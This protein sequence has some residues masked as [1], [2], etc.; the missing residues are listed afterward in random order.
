MGSTSNFILTEV[1]FTAINPDTGETLF[2]GRESVG[3]GNRTGLQGEL[4]TCTAAPETLVDPETGEP[5]TF[6]V[7]AEGFLTSRGR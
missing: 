4:I 5:F 7:R 2:L 3:Q 6:V 1:T